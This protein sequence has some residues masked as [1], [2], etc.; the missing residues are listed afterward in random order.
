MLASERR[1]VD[2]LIASDDPRTRAVVTEWVDGSLHEMPQVL[3][4]GVVA[5]S[6]GFAL[7]A[8]VVPGGTAAALDLLDRSPVGLLRQYPRLFRSLVLFG[9][10]ELAPHEAPA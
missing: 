8:R 10:L 6:L 1:V 9:E 7:L 2:A 5:Q 4:A 3:R